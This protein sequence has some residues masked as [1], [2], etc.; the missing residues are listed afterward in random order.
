[1][2]FLKIMTTFWKVICASYIKLSKELKN[3]I[4]I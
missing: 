4:K 1:M 2:L 3:I